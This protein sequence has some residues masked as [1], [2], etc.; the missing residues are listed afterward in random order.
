[1][2]GSFSLINSEH[3]GIDKLFRGEK[4]AEN[5]RRLG[6]SSYAACFDKFRDRAFRPTDRL[7]TVYNEW[8]RKKNLTSPYAVLHVRLGDGNIA[9]HNGTKWRWATQ[10]RQATK[11]SNDSVGPL[12][13]IIDPL[14]GGPTIHT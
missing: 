8:M 9:A 1:M 3:T 4:G 7:L 11:L 5:M 10:Q 13:R 14:A 2:S 12:Q 6:C